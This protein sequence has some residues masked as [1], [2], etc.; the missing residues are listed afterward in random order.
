MAK[1]VL[2]VRSLKEQAKGRQKALRL[3]TAVAKMRVKANRLEH[4]AQRLREKIEAYEEKANS[5]DQGVVPPP[6]T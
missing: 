6:K 3:R 4:R 1:A 2:D 5:L